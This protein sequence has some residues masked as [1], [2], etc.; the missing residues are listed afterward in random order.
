MD[1]DTGPDGDWYIADGSAVLAFRPDGS[2]AWR[3]SLPFGRQSEVV[4]LVYDPGSA[5][6]IA[7][8]NG[9][10]AIQHLATDGSLLSRW[11]SPIPTPSRAPGGLGGP[12]CRRQR[13]RV[14]PGPGEPAGGHRGGRH[15]H[16]HLVPRWPGAPPGRSF[17]WDGVHPRAGRLGALVH[18][19][20]TACRSFRRRP[21]GVDRKSRALRPCGGRSGRRLYH[22]SRERLGHALRLGCRRVADLRAAPAPGSGLPSVPGYACRTRDAAAGRDRPRPAGP[23]RRLRQR[24]T[25]SCAGS[26][27]GRRPPDRPTRPAAGARAGGGAG[28]RSRA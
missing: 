7:L 4:G 1:A 17:G 5:A 26:G 15:R 2:R 27:A 20:G 10:P 9:S 24:A 21:L 19:V 22:R 3:A 25:R 14:R 28:S 16:Q 8:D 23:S 12:R 6:L 13:A 18:R 11:S